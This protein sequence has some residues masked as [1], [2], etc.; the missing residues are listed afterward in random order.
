MNTAWP[1]P[2]S[3]SLS[4][5]IFLHTHADGVLQRIYEVTSDLG[6]RKQ[7]CVFVCVCA[8]LR[9]YVFFWGPTC[10]G[11]T[12]FSQGSNFEYSYLKHNISVPDLS[13]VLYTVSGY[14]VPHSI[15]SS[16]VI[17]ECCKLPDY[18]KSI[19]VS[20]ESSRIRSPTAVKQAGYFLSLQL[21]CVQMSLWV[22]VKSSAPHRE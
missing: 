21:V 18:C 7:L 10:V 13:T 19:R 15:W 14:G 11:N 2:S 16:L 6:S 22:L 4:L 5:Q 20:P 9:R 3:P 1:W 12:P 8:H 17:P